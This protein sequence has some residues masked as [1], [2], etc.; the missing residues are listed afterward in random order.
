MSFRLTEQVAVS[1][2]PS[3]IAEHPRRSRL[4]SS[5]PV[6]G[7]QR[8]AVRVSRLLV[9]LAELEW[10]V[11]GWGIYTLGGVECGVDNGVQWGGVLL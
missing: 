6:N 3:P 10:S 9:T 2:S 4:S 1:P 7:A 11:V 5:T 8:L